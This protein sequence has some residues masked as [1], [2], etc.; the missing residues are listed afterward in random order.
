[1]RQAFETNSPT[2][3]EPEVLEI[4]MKSVRDST[5]THARTPQPEP[6]AA[7]TMRAICRQ[8]CNPVTPNVT[9]Q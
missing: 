2:T 8:R 9:T 6:P 3:R 4:D 5:R 1:M 7:L